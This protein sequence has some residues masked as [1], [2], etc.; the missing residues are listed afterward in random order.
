MRYLLHPIPITGEYYPLTNCR[1]WVLFNAYCL[2]VTFNEENEGYSTLQRSIIVEEGSPF[3]DKKQS[4]CG[5]SRPVPEFEVLMHPEGDTE[6]NRTLAFQ[7]LR[8]SVEADIF[9]KLRDGS[10]E[11]IGWPLIKIAGGFKHKIFSYEIMEKIAEKMQESDFHEEDFET[12]PSHF[13]TSENINWNKSTAWS[14]R[15]CYFHIGVSTESLFECFPE[16]KPKMQTIVV[17]NRGGALIF[18]TDS[19]R[20][21][22]FEITSKRG[23]RAKYDWNE[24]PMEVARLLVSYGG[25]PENKKTLEIDIINWFKEKY[26]IA[27]STPAIRAK[28]K[29]YYA[30]FGRSENKPK[31]KPRSARI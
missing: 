8:K 3:F 30:A 21:E 24:F 4:F 10:L 7:A 20:N 29:P 5:Y 15:E 9:S 27:P 31:K 1:L 12:I 13:W 6:D 2:R 25:I 18:D 22:N 19:A 28:L 16:P 14:N 23:A 26:D 17:E 11:A